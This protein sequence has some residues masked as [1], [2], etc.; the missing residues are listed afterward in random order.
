[1]RFL[2]PRRFHGL[3][4]QKYK[5]F[6]LRKEKIEFMGKKCGRGYGVLSKNTYF[7]ITEIP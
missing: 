7:C 5:E 3:A 6:G 4:G 1:M 2:W